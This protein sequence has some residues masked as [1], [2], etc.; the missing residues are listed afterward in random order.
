M[1][2]VSVQINFKYFEINLLNTVKSCLLHEPSMF[3]PKL[4][5][6]L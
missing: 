1:A 4:E 6:V 3:I 5:S 2:D